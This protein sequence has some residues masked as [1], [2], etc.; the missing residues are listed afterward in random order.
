[1][2]QIDGKFGKDLNTESISN[3]IRLGYLLSIQAG[4]TQLLVNHHEGTLYI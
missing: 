1:M 4:V 2:K 3:I